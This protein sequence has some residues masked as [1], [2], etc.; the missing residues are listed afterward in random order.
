MKH[1]FV[2]LLD[3]CK[4]FFGSCLLLLSNRFYVVSL[5]PVILKFENQKKKRGGG[6]RG[7]G[8]RRSFYLLP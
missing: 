7:K 3:F 2:E 6:E 8:V 4:L 1:F 5:F